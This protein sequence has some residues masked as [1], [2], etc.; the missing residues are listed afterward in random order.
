MQKIIPFKKETRFKENVSEITS[1]SLEHSLHKE[2][3]N[4]ITGEFLVSGEYKVVDTSSVI[5]HFSFHLPFD[6]HLDEK[7]D[8]THTEI[9]IDDFY[10]E[11]VNNDTLLVNIDVLVNKIEE[12]QK[13]VEF[14]RNIEVT[15]LE[16]VL[17][18][19]EKEAEKERDRD[20]IEENETLVTEND[21]FTEIDEKVEEEREDIS[22]PV[23]TNIE[24]V[25]T[26]EEISS[27]FDDMGKASSSATYRVYIVRDEDT[28]DSIIVKYSIS[29]ENL[30]KYNNLNEI[31]K[32]DKLIIPCIYSE[33]I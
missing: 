25:E 4:L 23:S 2:E 15:P 31:K 27:V 7:Y 16:D 29:K 21:T 28:L 13:E 10:Y 19:A 26:R 33:K 22:V 30:E 5:D 32:G 3:N 17:A 14:V 8:I 11:V 12:K 9:D 1:I 24:N 18:E 6:I 20:M